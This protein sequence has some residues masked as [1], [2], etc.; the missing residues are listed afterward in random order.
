MTPMIDAIT[1]AEM[2]R[3]GLA[4]LLQHFSALTTCELGLGVTECLSR[5]RCL[6]PS[7]AVVRSATIGPARKWG[8]FQLPFP[9]LLHRAASVHRQHFDPTEV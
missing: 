4:P 1:D 7:P 8:V 2:P 5:K 3:A 9:E 6:F